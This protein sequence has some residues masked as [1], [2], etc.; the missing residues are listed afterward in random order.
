MGRAVAS[1][2]PAHGFEVVARIGE[3]RGDCRA[4]SRA[5]AQRRGGRGG[6]HHAAGGARRTSARLRRRAA[7]PVVCGTTGW[8]AE[9]A[10]VGARSSREVG[11]A[12][13]AAPNFSHR[14]GGCS[15]APS[16]RAAGAVRRRPRA[17]TRTSSRRITRRSWTRRRAPRS[18]LRGSRRRRLGHDVPITSVRIGSVPGTHEVIFDARSSRS[19]WPH[20]RATGA[21]SPRAPC[22]R[23]T[24]L[25]GRRG[26]F[27][28]R[29]V[30]TDARRLVRH[31]TRHAH[32][33]L[34][35][36]RHA[37]RP[38]PARS[39]RTRFAQPRANGRS[40]R[41][42]TVSCPCGS[43]GEA[44]TMSLD[45]H[46]RVVRARASSSVN[47]RVPV[48]AGAG[49]QRHEDGDRHCRRRWTAPARRTCCTSRRCTA[50]RRSAAS[51]RT[52]EAIAD[53][54]PLPIV[55][56]NVPGPHGEQHRGGDHARARRAPEHR[57][58]EGSVG[59]SRAR[60]PR[61]SWPRG[62]SGF[63]VLSGDDAITLAVMAAGGDGIIS[64]VSNAT[65]RLMA[66]AVP[67][68][69]RSRRLRRGARRCT[70]QLHALDAAPRSRIESDRRQ[71]RARHD[72]AH[73]ERAPPAARA[74]GRRSTTPPCARASSNTP[75]RCP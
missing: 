74:A 21:C 72:G 69:A 49:G 46:R 15:R 48:V 61:S 14:R 52:S 63:S 34:H 30:L 19:G 40:P 22:S 44:A 29:D 36:A 11:G 71:G 43:T 38:P 58:G 3:S 7:V 20:A 4:G 62:R 68:R 47:G 64:V 60:S 1:L 16:K 31:D 54:S 6:V 41:E 27:T 73:P 9:R 65:P 67:T 28:L 25:V 39:T 35:R 45:E 13:L 33:V 23:R 42:S 12:L 24:W 2:A 57:G 32:R 75:A 50:S 51:S 53:A 10:E 66:R 55:V 56:Y 5:A 37:V 70:S 59:Q 26:I 18:L 8:D 17:S